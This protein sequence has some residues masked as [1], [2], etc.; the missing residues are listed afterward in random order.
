VDHSA[1]LPAPQ[2]WRSAALIAG[3]VATVELAVLLVAGFVVFGK[4]F[5]DEVE[6]ANDPTTVVRAAVERGR[7]QPPAPGAGAAAPKELLTRGETSVIVLNGNGVPGAASVA[8]DRVRAHRYLVAGAENAPR[9]DFR[10]SLVMFR[11]GFEGEA[12]R[13]A[14]DLGIRRVAPLDGLRARDLQGA[15]LAFV[16]GG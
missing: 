6:K 13:L 4:Y 2:P 10:R 5:A 12:K 3:T 7:A 9:S 11:P 14:R 16:V 1:R 8:A 15:H